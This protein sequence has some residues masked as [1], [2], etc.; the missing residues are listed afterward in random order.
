MNAH[1]AKENIRHGVMPGHIDDYDLERSRGYL[2]ALN[3]PEVSRLVEAL[4]YCSVE[5]QLLRP[6]NNKQHVIALDALF[7]FKKMVVEND[8]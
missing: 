2:E 5:P 8:E 4:R 7:Q 6:E 3:G 1:E